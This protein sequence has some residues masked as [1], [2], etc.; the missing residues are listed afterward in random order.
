MKSKGA[1]T[2]LKFQSLHKFD[3]LCKFGGYI[4][5]DL[6]AA[7]TKLTNTRLWFVRK[8]SRAHS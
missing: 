5:T 7:N 2:N 3:N 8:N 4:T 6:Y 1:K